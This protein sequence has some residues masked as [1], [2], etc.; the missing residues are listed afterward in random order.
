MC[1]L[2]VRDRLH[3]FGVWNTFDFFHLIVHY[4]SDFILFGGF[5]PVT[6]LLIPL[7]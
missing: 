4:L 7:R 2:S 6:G 1:F 5:L 3:F